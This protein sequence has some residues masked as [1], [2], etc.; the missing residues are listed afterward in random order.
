MQGTAGGN[1]FCFLL[2]SHKNQVDKFTPS[3]IQKGALTVP[4]LYLPYLKMGHL[5]L[6]FC[7]Q[8]ISLTVQDR[9]ITSPGGIQQKS[10]RRVQR[11]VTLTTEHHFFGRGV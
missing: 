10:L 8:D 9:S 4:R 11:L 1:S 3:A 2:H 6:L 7:L 5:D